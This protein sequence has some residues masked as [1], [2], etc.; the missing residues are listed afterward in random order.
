[1]TDAELLAHL[2][3]TAKRI[4]L[5]SISFLDAA[6]QAATRSRGRWTHV[7]LTFHDGTRISIPRRLESAFLDQVFNLRKTR[8]DA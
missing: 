6:G 7:Y 4:E 2:A 8:D 3:E 5:K 1:M